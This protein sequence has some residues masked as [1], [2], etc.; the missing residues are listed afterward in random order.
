MRRPLL[1]TACALVALRASDTARSVPDA[2]A[3]PER[4]PLMVVLHGDR[5]DARDSQRRWAAPV[6]RLGWELLALDCPEDLGCKGGSW[7]RWDGD[8]EWLRDQVSEVVRTRSIDRSRIFLVG[9]SGGATYIGKHIQDWPDMFAA[10]V[11]HGG[12]V[13]PVDDACIDRAFPAYFLVGDK[14]PAHGAAREL[15]AYL[16]GCGQE[17][18]WDLVRGANH[19][20]EDA[21]LTGDKA[22]EILV[23]LGQRPR[24][25]EMARKN[26]P[27]TNGR[28]RTSHE[29][30][31]S[32]VGI[33]R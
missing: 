12:G 4:V 7:Y 3:T 1:L 14:N 16:E 22:D 9:W 2:S 28:L 13:A 23:W 26:A 15:R 29:V 5:E 27:R 8:T 21:A 6:A 33:A 31:R 19:A 11:L 30:H 20:E 18:R 10:T 25:A 32:L 24:A 17:V